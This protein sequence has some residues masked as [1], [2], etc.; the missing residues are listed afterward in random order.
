MPALSV[1]QLAPQPTAELVHV[2]PEM[3]VAWLNKNTKNRTL[4]ERKVSTY[5]AQMYSGDWM[6]T[7]DGPKFDVNG[8][9]INGQHTLKAVVDSGQT[10]PMFV[11]HNM[12]P[13]SQLV[14][15][16]GAKRTVADAL[17]FAGIKGANLNILAA[18]VRIGILWEEGWYRRSGQ[19]SNAAR[20]VTSLETL[21]WLESNK[22]AIA[23]AHTA[24][25]LRKA[26][27]MPPSVIGFA[28][29]KLSRIDSEQTAKFFSLLANFQTQGRGD[30]IFTMIRRY[31]GAK[32]SREKLA[33]AQH[34]FIT[35]RTW[36]AWRAGESLYQLKMGNVSTNAGRGLSAIGIPEP[37]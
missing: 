16:T 32:D 28:V 33:T 5:A 31:Q 36:N 18:A 37:K 22:D 29:M 9:L 26:I 11:F 13:D 12:H 1:K 34:L 25:L 24:D 30:P 20:E 17:K 7:G 4:R 8:R 10:V 3:A 14:M 23:A 6:V 19:A 2:T 27:P 21:E 35:F 15:D